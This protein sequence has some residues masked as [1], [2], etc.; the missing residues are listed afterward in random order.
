MRAITRSAGFFATMRMT[1]L[2]VLRRERH[3]SDASLNGYRFL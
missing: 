2:E 1:A 3:L